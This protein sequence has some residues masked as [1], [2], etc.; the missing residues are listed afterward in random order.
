M[1]EIAAG[2]DSFLSKP[3]E[4]SSSSS[5]FHGCDPT[6]CLGDNNT[7]VNNN[8]TVQTAVIGYALDV[9]VVSPSSTKSTTR[10]TTT[11]SQTTTLF[12]GSDETLQHDTTSSYESTTSIPSSLIANSNDNNTFA[13]SDFHVQFPNYYNDTKLKNMDCTSFS[14]SIQLQINGRIVPSTL[15]SMQL[16]KSSTSA[17][18]SSTTYTSKHCTFHQGNSCK[19]S[20]ETL[21]ELSTM[22]LSSGKNLLRYILHYNTT[23]TTTS[24]TTNNTS[25]S[26]R[27]ENCDITESSSF[28]TTQNSILGIAEAYI[29][30]WNVNDSILVSDIDGTVTKSDVRGFIDSVV[31]KTYIHAHHGVCA[32]FSKF[33][34]LPIGTNGGQV[35][36]M[37]LS[38]RPIS[39]IQSTREFI[40]SLSQRVHLQKCD[41][42]LDVNISSSYLT[43]TREGGGGGS[44]SGI[45][46]RSDYAL[47]SG[48]I[49]L[50]TGSVSDVLRIEF[51]TKSTHQFK[52]D[53]LRRHVVLPF[54]AAGR[55]ELSC[56]NDL[57]LA[58][59]GNKK[60]DALAYEMVGIRPE[61][62]YIIDKS[63]VL[64][65]SHCDN[66]SSDDFDDYNNYTEYANDSVTDTTTQM[67]KK[68]LCCT[69]PVQH[70]I[71]QDDVDGMEKSTQVSS[72]LRS[73]ENDSLKLPLESQASSKTFDAG[74]DSVVNDN[75]N[76]KSLR[77]KSSQSS[78]VK[79]KTSFSMEKERKKSFIGYTDKKLYSNIVRQISLS[80]SS[81]DWKE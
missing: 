14:Y 70:S 26:N 49:L 59:F 60:T 56:S 35:R 43:I 12:Q 39:L 20:S 16:P 75:R 55:N 62:I 53:M 47:P 11:D 32:F 78:S 25:N 65:S 6:Y 46:C 7:T 67:I 44:G 52:S 42:L 23:T 72:S 9:I 38:S 22:Y 80:Q 66:S 28:T 73:D 29:Y 68:L 33:S 48:P 27:N 57:F 79:S 17:T 71:F 3:S 15:V 8:N 18:S 10:A 31:T 36:V 34:Q 58:G 40:S 21:Y 41:S 69:S 61:N 54:A 13:S 76:N 64:T 4:S 50:H 81:H 2:A 19:L 63:S 74:N 45:S 37:Y 1:S 5:S 77:R 51:L 30:L 24:T